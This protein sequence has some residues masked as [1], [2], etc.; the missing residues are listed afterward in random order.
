MQMGG[1]MLHEDI[2]F[3]NCSYHTAVVHQKEAWNAVTEKLREVFAK[4][5]TGRLYLW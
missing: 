3:L 4:V 1:K 5:N 2:W